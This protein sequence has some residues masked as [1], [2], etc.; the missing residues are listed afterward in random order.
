METSTRERLT[1]ALLVV[2]AVVVIAPEL[3]SGRESVGRGT[4][5]AQNPEEGAPLQTYNVQLDAASTTEVPRDVPAAAAAQIAAVPPPVTQDVPPVSTAPVPQVA[6]PVENAA[7][8]AAARPAE[9]KP[10]GA[11]A[12]P[13]PPMPAAA[14]AGKWWVQLGSFASGENAQRLAKK[15]RAAGYAIDVSRGS[16]KGK[17]LYL[18]RAGPVADQAAASDL[19]ARLVAAGEKNPKLVAP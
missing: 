13:R 2:L 17:D 8:N 12:S 14:T 19:L 3:F 18:V 11:V 5:P 15:L 6:P 4:P 9:T 16:V 1:G 7:G 10:S